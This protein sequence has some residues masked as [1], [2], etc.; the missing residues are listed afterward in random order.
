MIVHKVY[1]FTNV[2]AVH[3]NYSIYVKTEFCPKF[4]MTKVNVKG[5]VSV[6]LYVIGGLWKNTEGYEAPFFNETTT[7]NARAGKIFRVHKYNKRDK[8]YKH[9]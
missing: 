8:Y 2:I 5:F 7:H 3:H 9:A 1:T 6:I 4:E